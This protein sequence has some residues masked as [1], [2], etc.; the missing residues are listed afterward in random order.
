MLQCRHYEYIGPLAANAETIVGLKDVFQNIIT[1]N[2]YSHLNENLMAKKNAVVV[3]TK[4]KIKLSEGCAFIA[5]IK[6]ALLSLFA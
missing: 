3:I 5:F 4:R 1:P 6:C 2:R